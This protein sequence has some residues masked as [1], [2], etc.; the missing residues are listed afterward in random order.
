[1]LIKETTI[2]VA[3]SKNYQ[4]AEFS[5]TAEV[6]SQEDIEKL[7]ASCIKNAIDSLE[8]LPKEFLEN[9]KPSYEPISSTATGYQ[10]IQTTPIKA[11]QR[12]EAYHQKQVK[13]TSEAQENYI[14]GLGYSG[15]IPSEWDEANKLIQQLKNR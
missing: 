6:D 13:Q 9:K 4:K 11:V 1:M 2:T 14:R 10:T 5:I 8:K 12:K 15:P 3:V 7:K